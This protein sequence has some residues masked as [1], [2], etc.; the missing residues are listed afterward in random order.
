MTT[1]VTL[2]ALGESV[3]EGTVSRWLK[4]VGDRVAADEPLLEVSTDKVDTEIPAPTD[5]VLLEILV[6]EDETAPVG[7]VLALI[8]QPSPQTAA[9]APEL[10]PAGPP[11]P[12][13]AAAVPPAPSG[14]DRFQNAEPATVLPAWAQ[15]GQGSFFA[16]PPLEPAPG[17]P[18]SDWT[19]AAPAFQP[20]S[21]SSWI[22][23]PASDPDRATLGD[24]RPVASIPTGPIPTLVTAVDPF[25]NGST[26]TGPIPNDPFSAGPAPTAPAPVDALGADPTPGDAS[27]AATTA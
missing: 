27:P 22:G 21:A 1:R 3:S 4:Q 20:D 13:P 26:A 10:D 5:G 14:M 12:Q 8:G 17:R 11:P 19:G 16:P 9:P 24:D 15:P 2:P 7:A 18:A 25:P 6:R 23:G